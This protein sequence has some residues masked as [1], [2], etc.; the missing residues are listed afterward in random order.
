MDVYF[1]R[2]DGQAVTCDDFRRALAEQRGR[3]VA[4]GALVQP[5]GHAL[6]VD[7][8]GHHDPAGRRYVL[9]FA[10]HTPPTPGQ[11]DKHPL[12]IPVRMALYD[13]NGTPLPLRLEGE[14]GT[15][16]TQR[17]LLVTQAAQRFV[18]TGID[19]AQRCPRCCRTTPRR[20]SCGAR[21][22]A[23]ELAFLARHDRDAFNRWDAIQRL[24]QAAIS[25]ALEREGG[26]AA[27]PAFARWSRPT[28]P[29]SATPARIR[30]G[31]R[32]A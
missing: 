23:A 29:C 17:V 4:V 26:L 16:P 19:V 22:I 31:W 12:P 6:R 9:D 8:H 21:S 25:A 11:A 27:A 28:P 10:Q 15:G 13:G 7:A 18:F 30:R 2:H 20:S 5:G 3:P 24:M 32:S 14:D 1:R